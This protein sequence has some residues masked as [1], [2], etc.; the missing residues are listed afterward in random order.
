[1]GIIDDVFVSK[2]PSSSGSKYAFR[3]QANAEWE[4]HSSATRRLRR[5]GRIQTNGSKTS[6][7]Q[8]WDIYREYHKEDLIFPARTAGF[9]IEEGRVVSD[10]QLLAKL[11]HF[12]AATGLIDFTWNPLIALW[13]ACAEHTEDSTKKDGKVFVVKL[14]DTDRYTNIYKR[15]SKEKE[16]LEDQETIEKLFP[17]PYDGRSLRLYW[18]PKVRSEA[19]ARILVQQSVFVLAHP[20][21]LQEVEGEITEKISIDSSAKKAIRQELAALGITQLSL[22]RDI[23]GFSVV[24][25]QDAPV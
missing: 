7:D 3:G 17:P 1:M 12:G 9:D 18:E 14:G 4:L 22:F 19:G 5:A 15:V 23:H 10:L 21:V 6:N 24:N 20:H 2:I 13:F 11:Q 16:T 25:D 8:L